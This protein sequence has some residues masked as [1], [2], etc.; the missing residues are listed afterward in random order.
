MR[1]T[2][3]DQRPTK[4]RP[5]QGFTLLEVILALALSTLVLA[6]IGFAISSH[7][8]FLDAGRTGV[9]E[10]QLARAI[11]SQI[12]DDLRNAVPGD[13][14]Q[15]SASASGSTTSNQ[16]S[17]G[18][19]GADA[20]KSPTGGEGEELISGGMSGATDGEGT[21]ATTASTTDLST[22]NPQ[23]TPGLFGNQ[24]QLEVDVSRLPRSD[25]LYGS[26]MTPGQSPL[27]NQ[28]GAV[29]NVIYYVSNDGTAASQTQTAAPGQVQG[30]GLYRREVDRTLALYSAQQGDQTTMQQATQLL[31]PEV[32]ALQFRYFDGTQWLEQWDSS[33]MGSL[34]MAIEIQIKL[35][36][37]PLTSRQL[38]SSA[39]YRLVVHPSVTQPTSSSTSSATTSSASSS[40]SGSQP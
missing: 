10:A 35:T 11:L 15:A 39:I 31:A 24:N 21:D 33:T 34:P 38:P 20:G 7:L 18:A 27:V 25:Q 3:N 17:G 37:R 8:R 4:E 22:A 13:S 32:E 5:A 9:E 6:A 12:A 26:I 29:K 36:R 14:S 30:Q 1:P 40:S 16:P 2:T 28:L 23:P 19:G